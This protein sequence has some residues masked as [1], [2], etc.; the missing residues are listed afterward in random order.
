MS[1]KRISVCLEGNNLYITV[2]GI[3]EVSAGCILNAAE[4]AAAGPDRRRAML[5]EEL[6]VC[7]EDIMTDD[8]LRATAAPV[9]VETAHVI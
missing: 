1:V 3:V 9:W 7:C 5:E 8:A 2:P 6:R 4:W